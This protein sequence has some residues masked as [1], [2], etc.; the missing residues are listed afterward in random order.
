MSKIMLK[1]LPKVRF[2]AWGICVFIAVLLV[3]ILFVGRVARQAPKPYVSVRF[4]STNFFG[5]PAISIEVSNKMSFNVNCSIEPQVLLSR[6][7]M[8][9]A[10]WYEQFHHP[11][12]YISFLRPESIQTSH[13]PL[14]QQHEEPLYLEGV[15]VRVSFERALKPVETSVLNKMPWVKSYYPFNPRRSSFLLEGPR[16]LGYKAVGA[17][18]ANDQTFADLVSREVNQAQLIL[19]IINAHLRERDLK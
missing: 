6:N 2:R 4:G 1:A 7:W 3:S 10:G 15:R 17:H 19:K 12:G 16:S 18:H 11:P 9:A 5:F 13:I 8:C 14:K